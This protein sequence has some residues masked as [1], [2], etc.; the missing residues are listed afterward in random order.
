MPYSFVIVLLLY[1][2]LISFCISCYSG[3]IEDREGEEERVIFPTKEICYQGVTLEQ[4]YLLIGHLPPLYSPSFDK[5]RFVVSCW[6]Y[7]LL[8]V[9]NFMSFIYLGFLEATRIYLWVSLVSVQY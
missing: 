1:L 4:S 2:L 5:S 6:S 9:L 8:A 7:C 3:I